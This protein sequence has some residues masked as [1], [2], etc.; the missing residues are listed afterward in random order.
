VHHR[1]ANLLFEFGPDS[2]GVEC[3]SNR[4]ADTAKCEPVGGRGFVVAR[5]KPSNA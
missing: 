4:L 2:L 5:W 1:I 3:Q